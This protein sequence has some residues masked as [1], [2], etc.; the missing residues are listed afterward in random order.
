MVELDG[1]DL[2]VPGH[3]PVGPPGVE[4]EVIQRGDCLDRG[5]S[6]PVGGGQVQHFRGRVGAQRVGGATVRRIGAVVEH[7]G[8]GGG[9]RADLAGVDRKS[10][11]LNSSHVAISYAVFSLKKKKKQKKPLT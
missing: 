3:G 11:R 10:T 7:G 8:V 2:R 9:D 4:G 1:L 5:A 6:E